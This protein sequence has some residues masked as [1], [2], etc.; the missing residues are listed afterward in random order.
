MNCR[1]RE[2]PKRSAN[3]VRIS[4][5]YR[6]ISTESAFR[7]PLETRL[8][9]QTLCAKRRWALQIATVFCKALPARLIPLFEDRESN[10]L[11][12]GCS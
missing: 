10:R 9:P 3:K 5:I 4:A 12:R 2:M 11:N 1:A 7:H 6:K 8:S